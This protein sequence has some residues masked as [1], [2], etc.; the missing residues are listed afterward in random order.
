MLVVASWSS[1]IFNVF[2]SS[3]LTVVVAILVL[4]LTVQQ[5]VFWLFISLASATVP[6]LIYYYQFKKGNL[7]SFWSPKKEE[8]VAAHLAWIGAAVVFS[9]LAFGLKA[10]ILLL[11]LGLVFLVLAIINL[12][13]S[14]S[15]KISVHSEAITLFVFTSIMTVSVNMIF[16]ALLIVLVGWSRVYL[17]AHT[18]LEVSTGVLVS[19]IVVFAIFSLF[20]LAT[21]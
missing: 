21:F 17:K 16:L 7:S 4:S 19:I 13:F 1:K 8:R 2:T 6:L 9:I 14:T 18:L 11:A 20:G 15:F 12:L 5:K 10:P 3:L